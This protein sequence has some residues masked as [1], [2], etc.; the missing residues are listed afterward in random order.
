MLISLEYVLIF[1]VIM[2]FFYFISK[3]SFCSGDGFNVGGQS[4]ECSTSVSNGASQSFCLDGKNLLDSKICTG[5]P[6]EKA[7]KTVAEYMDISPLT[8]TWTPKSAPN[9][10]N[11]PPTPRRETVFCPNSDKQKCRMECPK[12]VC[13]DN[14]CAMRTNTCCDFY[15]E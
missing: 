8:C 5:Q 6:D 3:P 9:P 11:P 15:C 14:Q 12:P 2:G 1:A 10:P 7:C 13:P 4:C